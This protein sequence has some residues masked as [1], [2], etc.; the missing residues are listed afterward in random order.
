MRENEQIPWVWEDSCSPICCE[1]NEALK[2]KKLR[3]V[4]ELSGN[5]FSFAR[6]NTDQ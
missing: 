5:F 2:L 3:E 6:F 4:L 1:P